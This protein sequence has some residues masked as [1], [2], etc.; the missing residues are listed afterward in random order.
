MMNDE[1]LLR[2]FARDRSRAAFDEILRRHGGLVFGVCRRALGDLQEAEDAAQSVFL[3]FLEKAPRLGSGTVLGAWLYRTAVYVSRNQIRARL[4]RESRPPEPAPPPA[5]PAWEEA[6]PH[7]DDALSRLPQRLQD[8]LV[9]HYLQG[10]TLVETAAALDCP[11]KTLEKRV[12]KGLERLREILTGAGVAISS[13]ALVALLQQEARGATPVRVAE[14]LRTRPIPPP[15]ARL[16]PKLLFPATAALVAAG[17]LAG[18]LRMSGRDSTEPAPRTAHVDASAAPG[19][20]KDPDASTA[21]PATAGG[22]PSAGLRRFPATFEELRALYKR[23]LEC[24]EDASRW[25]ALGI[26]VGVDDL[27]AVLSRED[28]DENWVDPLIVDLLKEWA[29]REPRP[30]AEWLYRSCAL[31]PTTGEWKIV[32]PRDAGPANV[33]PLEAVLDAWVRREPAAAEAWMKSLPPGL[34]RDAV[35]VELAIVASRRDPDRSADFAAMLDALPP[36]EARRVATALVAQEWAKRDPKSAAAWILK[37]PARGA[38]QEVRPRTFSLDD[39]RA[40]PGLPP[41]AKI[42]YGV[43]VDRENPAFAA[44]L[45]DVAQELVEARLDALTNIAHTW[46]RSDLAAARLWSQNLEDPIER[47]SAMSRI[48][49]VWAETDPQAVLEYARAHPESE[50]RDNWLTIVAKGMIGSDRAGAESVIRLVSAE[51]RDAMWCHVLETLRT[52]RPEQAARESIDSMQQGD[53]QKVR[54]EYNGVLWTSLSSW[55]RRDPRAAAD[56]AQAILKKEL[57]ENVIDTVGHIWANSDPRA[58]LD[59][60]FRLPEESR[61]RLVGYAAA[62]LAETDLDRARRLA[63]QLT[64]A[65]G[66]SSAITGV[67]AAWGRTE[68]QAAL[69]WARSLPAPERDYCI[70]TVLAAWA[71]RDADAA[72]A[73]VDSVPDEETRFDTVQAIQRNRMGALRMKLRESLLLRKEGE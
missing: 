53:W 35:V 9:V 33:T 30:A 56:C 70:A 49:A 47:S 38:G 48:G 63:L 23:L 22:A 28:F 71:E 54:G 62:G 25:E 27:R 58:V 39:P 61:G 17:C 50:W 40:D 72:L 52:L 37:L 18:A 6:R 4:R 14:A 1:D 51:N 15:G 19:H 64:E 26:G 31:L 41:L 21:A 45:P 7:L 24:P 46:A 44:E 13:A 34:A 36:S 42:D 69:V 10:K 11:V 32:G 8:A 29:G 73:E 68:P 60:A 12:G 5:E 20:P 2:A 67:A 57:R 55:V 66:R 16:L 59:W 65:G 3:I 43:I